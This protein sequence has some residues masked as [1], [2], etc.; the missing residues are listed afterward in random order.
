MLCF[1][2]FIFTIHIMLC[3][4]FLNWKISCTSDI[5]M[6]KSSFLSLSSYFYSMSSQPWPS[7]LSFYISH[8]LGCSRTFLHS[9][10]LEKKLITQV[11]LR[12][13][14]AS[15]CL[16]S[17]QIISLL[18]MLST[19]KNKIYK[20]SQWWIYIFSLNLI[21]CLDI[22]D[23]CFISLCWIFILICYILSKS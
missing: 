3:S 23:T 1:F 22:G 10:K 4:H 7:L 11:I 21:K 18:V 9:R 19:M 20:E 14:C 12:F 13:I 16:R 8:V 17:Q 2:V 15:I 6:T 5:I